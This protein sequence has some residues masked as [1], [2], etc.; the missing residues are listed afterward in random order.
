MEATY[1]ANILIIYWFILTWNVKV[2]GIVDWK[3][4]IMKDF[5]VGL[6]YLKILHVNFIVILQLR[7]H[8]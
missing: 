4:W 3:C 2:A 1:F 6:G 7:A 5:R 8:N